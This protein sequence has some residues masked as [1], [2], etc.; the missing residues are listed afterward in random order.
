MLLKVVPVALL[1]D[2]KQKL[3]TVADAAAAAAQASS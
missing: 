2:R 1:E 3:Q